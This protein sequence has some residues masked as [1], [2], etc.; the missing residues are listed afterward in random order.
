MKG[1]S[2]L[3]QLTAAGTP[4]FTQIG[5]RLRVTLINIETDILRPIQVSVERRITL[6]ADV[7][8]TFNT[9]TL[10]FSPTDTTRL[11]RVAL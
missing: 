6:L 5:G 1:D 4:I 9:L 8:T 10:V 7:Q 11:A 3:C 2:R